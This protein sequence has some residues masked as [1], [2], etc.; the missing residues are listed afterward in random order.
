[1]VSSAPITWSNTGAN[2]RHIIIERV[3][4]VGVI[5]IGTKTSITLAQD[6]RYSFIKNVI[7]IIQGWYHRTSECSWDWVDRRFWLNRGS[8][9]GFGSSLIGINIGTCSGKQF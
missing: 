7:E 3:V 6:R 5:V 1:M 9:I 4:N 8:R 2:I